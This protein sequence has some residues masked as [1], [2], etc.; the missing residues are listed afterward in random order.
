[1][2]DVEP[3]RDERG[4]YTQLPEAMR[5]RMWPKGV[6]GNPK[7][8]GGEYQR[9]LML[10]REASYDAAKEII[11]LSKESEDERVRYMAATWIVERAWGKPQNYDPSKERAPTGFNPADYSSEQLERIESALR[12]IMAVRDEME[13]ATL[14][15][16]SGD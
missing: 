4:R 16:Q 6:S 12:V 15:G 7:G 9:C 5:Q 8:H 14:A 2:S 1:M 10:C 11:R 13:A 3:S